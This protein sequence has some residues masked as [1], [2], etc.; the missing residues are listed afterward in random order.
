M[1]WAVGVLLATKHIRQIP[2]AATPS[3]RP[4]YTARSVSS[5]KANPMTFAQTNGTKSIGS[6]KAMSTKT[7]NQNSNVDE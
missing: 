4:K 6:A 2:I 1:G 3:D 7:G 5:G